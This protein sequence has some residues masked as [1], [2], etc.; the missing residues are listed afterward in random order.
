MHLDYNFL[1][2][3]RFNKTRVL[4]SKTF[5]NFCENLK[6]FGFKYQNELIIALEI[7]Y[8]YEI[9]INQRDKLIFKINP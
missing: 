8:F 2:E 7:C 6:E 3:F 9:E 4:I 5:Q 1:V